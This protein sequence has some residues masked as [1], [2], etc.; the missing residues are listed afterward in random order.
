MVQ[1][2]P[3]KLGQANVV[4]V[5]EVDSPKGLRIAGTLPGDSLLDDPP[6]PRRILPVMGRSQAVRDYLRCEVGLPDARM[7]ALLSP[8][9]ERIM[10][11]PL[12]PAR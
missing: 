3:L 4:L 11:T 10:S 2:R 8:I 9:C 12:S 5:D 6:G 1:G 7:Q